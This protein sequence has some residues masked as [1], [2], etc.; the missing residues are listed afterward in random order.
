[1][2]DCSITCA[3]DITPPVPAE[4]LKTGVLADLANDT[5]VCVRQE[6]VDGETHSYIE[7]A[8]DDGAYAYRIG[9]D[10]ETI[11]K[12]L[13]AGYTYSGY[14]QVRMEDT[15]DFWQVRI[16]ESGHAVDDYPEIVYPSDGRIVLTPGPLTA[17]MSAADIETALVTLAELWHDRGAE[18]SERQAEVAERLTELWQADQIADDLDA[19]DDNDN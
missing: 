4:L 11:V 5:G 2:G 3:I 15:D 10:I 1:M 17:V 6:T 8:S 13:G 12:A 16:D 7:R 18:L 14:L 9:D 19:E